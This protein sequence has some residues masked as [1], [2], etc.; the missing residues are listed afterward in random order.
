MRPGEGVKVSGCSAL[1]RH[2]MAWPRM[3]EFS[4]RDIRISCRVSPAAMRIWLFTRSTPVTISVTGCSTWMRAFT[5]MKYR[6]PSA[7]IRNSTVPA[8]V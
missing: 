8:L 4:R 3:D 6:L 5:S 1:M 2:S 7:S